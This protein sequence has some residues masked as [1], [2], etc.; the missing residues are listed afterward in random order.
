[1]IWKP[2]INEVSS[3]FMYRVLF[4]LYHYIPAFFY[5]MV[6]KFQGSKTRMMDIYNKVYYETILLDFF[7]SRTWKFND[8]NMRQLHRDMSKED[9]DDFPLTLRAE[10]Y[11]PHTKTTSDGFRKY[12]F[13]ENDND[14]KSALKLYKLFNL[15][16]NLLLAVIYGFIFYFVYIY[17]LK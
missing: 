7:A 11:E 4:V 2:T 13:K 17:F 9:H 8:I 15:L 14:L 16:H 3:I 6:L 1:M 5:D 12:F 10:D